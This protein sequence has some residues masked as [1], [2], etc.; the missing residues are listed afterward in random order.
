M[1]LFEP[2]RCTDELP[3]DLE[4]DY[5][6]AEEKLD[7]SRYVLYLGGNPYSESSKEH[8]LLSRRVSSVN[9]KHVDR[10]KNVPHITEKSYLGL[11]DTVLDGEIMGKDF[12]CTNSVMNSSPMV[13]VQKQYE[14]KLNYHVFD[15]MMFRGVDVRGYPLEKRRK[16]LLAIVDRMNNPHV[17]PIEQR[18]GDIGSYFNEVISKGGEG[19][20]VKDLRQGYGRGWCKKKKSYDVSCVISGFKAGT[21][22]YS[23][24]VGSIALAVYVQGELVEVG[25]ASGFSDSMRIDMAKNPN[26]YLGKVV[27]IFCHEIQASK[28]SSDN[29]VG[30]LRHPTYHRIRDDLNPLDCTSE[31]LLEDIKM[32]LRSNRNKSTNYYR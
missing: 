27:D 8:A 29:P 11:E 4:K 21:G 6:V 14:E 19:L 31:K 17:I 32:Q 7:G 9:G 22:K 28:R 25:F 20:I 18:Q 12:L 16:I 1:K 3:D 30:R 15:V 26:K 2:A 24:S 23:N 5:L 10:T 13:A